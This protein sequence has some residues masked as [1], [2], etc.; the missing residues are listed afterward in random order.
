MPASHPVDVT[1]MPEEEFDVLRRL[2]RALDAGEP[3]PLVEFGSAVA[4][5]AEPDRFTMAPDPAPRPSL[6]E[7]ADAFAGTRLPV[8]DAATVAISPYL[9]G[10]TRAR[11]LRDVRQRGVALPSWLWRLDDIR[12]TQASLT[13]HILGDGDNI[14]I[15]LDVPGATATLVVYVDHNAGTVV[16]DAFTAPRSFDDAQAMMHTAP[17]S[18]DVTTVPLSL[19]DARARLHEAVENG[20]MLYPPFET[21]TWPIIRP[22]TEWMLRLMPEGGVGY[23][24]EEFDD[25]AR[26]AL[27]A[28][29]ITSSAAGALARTVPGED[30]RTIADALVWFGADY[31]PGDPLRW[32]RVSVEV[33]LADWAPRK[34]IADLDY[35]R[36]FPAVLRAFV[37]FAHTERSIPPELTRDTLAAVGRYEQD[38]LDAVSRPH[39]T[40]PE[41]LLERMGALP[42]LDDDIP[43]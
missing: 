27:V 37:R 40:G 42:P 43:R 23:V 11:V 5:A 2:Q 17:G 14:T 34:V 22:F 21:D 41:A 8:T 13:T 3:M 15:G 31:G 26:A 18:E 32:S 38:F 6:N 28:R 29:F 7:M 9:D 19:A 4:A 35:L 33:F 20:R 30:V 1:D 25:D 39:R 12:P 24:R 10:L 36:H 16:K